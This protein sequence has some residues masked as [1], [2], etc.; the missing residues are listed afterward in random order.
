MVKFGRFYEMILEIGRNEKIGSKLHPIIE[1]KLVI[2]SPLTLDLNISRGI[3]SKVNTGMFSLY[4][5]NEDTRNRLVKDR[6]NEEKY[7]G[8]TLTAGYEEGGWAQIFTGTIKEC[9]SYKQS[10]STVFKTDIE[11]W[12][13]GLDVYQAVANLSFEAGTPP[14]T[15]IESLIAEMPTTKLGTISPYVEF[16]DSKRGSSLIG[17]GMDR[18][19][20]I[21]GN[22]AFIDNQTLNIL[23]KFDDAFIGNLDVINVD[24]GLLG[25]P[26]R[27]GT[28]L[29]VET[30][31]EPDLLIGQALKLVSSTLGYMDKQYKLVGLTHEGKISGAECGNL[32]TKMD[33]FIGTEIFNLIARNK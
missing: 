11:A 32:T 7:I 23:N 31:F 29:T 5:L 16:K 9:Y 12:D 19:Q 15:I 22:N 30:I 3:D 18:L 17:K 25:S 6:Y 28:T 26:R 24:S 33:L 8:L 13:G 20:E 1:E 27:N 10:G 4:G 14:K 21:C 2:E